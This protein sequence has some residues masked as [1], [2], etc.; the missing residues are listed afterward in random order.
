MNTT[1]EKQA[2]RYR[3]QTHGY[4]RDMQKDRQPNPVFLHGDFPGQRSLAGYPTRLPRVGHDRSNLAR[5]SQ[6]NRAWGG[7]WREEEDGTKNQGAEVGN[8]RSLPPTF[9]QVPLCS[10]SLKAAPG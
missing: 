4:Q 9:Q 1:K 7:T 2:Y 3:V 5:R 6:H 10:W 8:K